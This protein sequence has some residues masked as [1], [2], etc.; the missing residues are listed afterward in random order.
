MAAGKSVVAAKLVRD[1]GITSRSFGSLVRAEASA[2]GLNP[3]DRETLQDL[4]ALLLNDLGGREFLRRAADH[5]C[6]PSGPGLVL[7]GIRHSRIVDEFRRVFSP[8]WIVFVDAS[9]NVL[10]ERWNRRREE[11]LE[12]EK[13]RAHETERELTDLRAKAD[14]VI[15]GDNSGYD[16]LFNYV[17][18]ALRPF[19]AK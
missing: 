3:S 8:T 11:G 6:E 18:S 1:L 12:I 16:H 2:R 4:G 7:D 13:A 5:P 17:S 19:E 14:L 9:A 10:Q 15:V